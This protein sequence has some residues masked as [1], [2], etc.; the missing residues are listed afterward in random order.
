MLVNKIVS[1]CKVLMYVY[2]QEV[3]CAMNI[4]PKLPC[5][6]EVDFIVISSLI[7]EI[8]CL[9]FEMQ[10]LIPPLDIAV[11]VDGEMFNKSM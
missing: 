3:I 4:H 6:A 10:T 9:A 8:C 2:F 11:G 7:R 1:E 5:P